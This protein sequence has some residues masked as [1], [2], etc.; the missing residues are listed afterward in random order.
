[1]A[2]VRDI[3]LMKL[4]A[5]SG[6]GSRKDFIDLHTILRDGPTLR[7]HFALLPRKYGASRINAY[8][9]LKSLTHFD[10][11]EAEPGVV[12]SGWPESNRNPAPFPQR[13]EDACGKY[14]L[15]RPAG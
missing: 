8:R 14:A 15:A 10:D 13:R 3:A 1:V 6:R 5:I 12:R 9:S 2:D 4:A 11:A 7:D